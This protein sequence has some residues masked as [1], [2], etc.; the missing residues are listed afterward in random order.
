MKKLLLILAGILG[1]LILLGLGLY[2]LGWYRLNR[3]YIATPAPILLPEDPERLLEGQ[4]IFRYRGCEACHGEDLQG[5][6]Y[7]DNPAIGEVITPNLTKGTGGI[8]GERSDLDL[9][10]AV[11]H[12]LDPDGKPL[13]FMPSTEFYYLADH[14]LGAVLAYIR[15]MPAVDNQPPP[16]QLSPTGFIVMNLT[17]EIT[18]IPAELIPHDTTPPAPPEPALSIAY[19]EYLSLSCPVCHGGNLSGG[20][21]PGF[22]P[23]WPAA[24]NLTAGSGSRLIAWGEEGF[25]DIMRDG[26]KHGRAIHPD[27]MPWSSYKYMSDLE[28]RAVYLYLVNKPAREYGK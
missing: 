9:I 14:D 6:V 26:E 11:R 17:R 27:Y 20:E 10:R 23:E 24:G 12:G 16:S 25:I 22:P 4:R 19:G 21:I 28:L 13:L 1:L 2:G 5:L 8:G 15:S 3:T 18:F 7:L